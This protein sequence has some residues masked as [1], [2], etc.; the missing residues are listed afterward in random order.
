MQEMFKKEIH[1]FS[2]QEIKFLNNVRGQPALRRV[3][4][5]GFRASVVYTNKDL[6]PN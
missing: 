5:I 2:M 6:R 4:T 3:A 1:T